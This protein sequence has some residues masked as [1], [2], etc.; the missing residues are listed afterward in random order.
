MPGLDLHAGDF[1]ASKALE[2]CRPVLQSDEKWAHAATL[3]HYNPHLVLE[4][5]VVAMLEHCS[6][7]S[8]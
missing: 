7:T 1:K 6:A 5:E 2:R 8:V 3:A 4:G